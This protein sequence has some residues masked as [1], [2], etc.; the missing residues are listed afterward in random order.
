M[1]YGFS[2][3]SMYFLGP[4]DFLEDSFN[5]KGKNLYNK[6]YFLFWPLVHSYE[7][8]IDEYFTKKKGLLTC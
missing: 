3:A 7:D 5:S 4:R 1:V 6:Q 2:S 8:S